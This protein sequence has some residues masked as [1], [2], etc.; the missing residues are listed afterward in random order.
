MTV[1]A[2]AFVYL[3]IKAKFIFFLNLID[4]SIATKILAACNTIAK[5][6]KTSHIGHNLLSEC[7]KNLEIK[8]GGLKCFIK[9]RWT[10][11]YEATYSIVRMKRALE[12]VIFFNNIF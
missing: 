5:F 12:E 2:K 3:L 1:T 8:G 6:F 10:S 4:H 9:T 11:M 7:A